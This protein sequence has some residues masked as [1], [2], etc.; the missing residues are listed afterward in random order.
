MPVAPVP[1]AA[2]VLSVSALTRRVRET[3]EG[4]FG[5]VWVSGE[6]SNLIRPNSGHL[7]FSL[8]DDK[9][10]LR[11]VIYRGIAFRVRFEPRDGMEVVVRGRLT[12]YEPRGDYQL[13]V[14]EIHPKGVGALELALQQLK[15][16]LQAK[17]YFDPRRKKKLPA[18]PRAIALVTSPSGAAVRDMLELLSRRWPVAAVTVVPVRV[19]GDGAAGE[20]A[21][22]IR[23]LNRLQAEGVIRLDAL[24]VGRG[25]GS[26]E[27]LWAFNEEPVAEAIFA[28]KI[29]V[30]SAIGHEIDVTI[31]DLVADHRALTP[32][33]AVTDLTPDLS[34]L[35]TGLTDTA[36]RMR[37]CLGRRLN[38]AR[39]RLDTFAGRRT[40][41]QPLD[42]IRD[43]EKR[44]DELDQRLGRQARQ[45]I[46]RHRDRVAAVAGRLHT[47][48]P[49]NVLARG[50]SLTYQPDGHLLRAAS[51][52]QP[53]DRLTT[54][55]AAGEVESRVEAVRPVA[56]ESP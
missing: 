43:L 48:S 50:Y 1:D 26:L 22:A 31:S 9:A 12:V 32:S 30:V 38:L 33:H 35:E 15:E 47:L 8:K 17:G 37:E 10:T 21:T 18:F 27:D 56:E 11:A 39:Q 19:Q 23:L 6:I 54:R 42:R 46:E 13:A 29:P 14:E 51:A 44:L 4:E 36:R 40:F 52:V 20:I 5:S 7:Y 3:L 49:L 34:A 53:G 28:S 45:T 25:G 16:K 24:I 55:L 41:R 2:D